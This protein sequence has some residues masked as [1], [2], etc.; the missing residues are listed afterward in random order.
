MIWGRPVLAVSVLIALALISTFAWAGPVRSSVEAQAM[1]QALLAGR[2]HLL[3]I[4]TVREVGQS[5]EVEV[6]TSG[7]TLVDRLLVE[8]SSGRLRS[9]YGQMLL[10][11]SPNGSSHPAVV[12]GG[13]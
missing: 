1:V 13:S 4:G 5:Y 3:K 9:L 2:T 7:D 6:V 11:L 8:K 12:P 10:S